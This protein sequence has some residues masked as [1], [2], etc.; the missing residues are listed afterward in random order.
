MTN[1]INII[2]LIILGAIVLVYLGWLNIKR[3]LA[4]RIREM[5]DKFGDQNV[6]R[7]A[8]LA[9]FFGQESIGMMQIRGNGMLV[10]TDKELYF[11]MWA[12][13]RELSIPVG[14]ILTIETPRS[15]LGKTVGRALLKV[16]FRDENGQRDSAAWLVRDLP[17][18]KGSLETLI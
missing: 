18:W 5:L 10:L 17:S 14:S 16:V 9:N 12:P 11:R 4:K 7:T 8:P 13:K 1:M 3:I 2:L 6:L 15:H